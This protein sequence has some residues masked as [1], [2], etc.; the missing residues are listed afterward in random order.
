M[1]KLAVTIDQAR[2]AATSRLRSISDTARLDA[3]IILS[4]AVSVDRNMLN[5]IRDDTLNSDQQSDFE[6]LLSRRMAG[7]PI[8]YIT[9][10]KEFWS[11]DL[12]V[13]DAT[14]VPR[15]E[16]E[17]VVE[18]TLF[19]CNQLDTPYI[20]DLGTGCGAIALALA[21]ELAKSKITAT[22]ISEDALSIAKLNCKR[23]NLDNIRFVQGN[24]TDALEGMR[25][26]II[27][28]NPP[29]IREDDLCLKDIFMLH[30][31]KLA[32]TGGEDGFSAI[33]RIVDGSSKFLNPGG[34]L[35]IEHGFDQPD[36]VQNLM[37][38]NGFVEVSTNSDLAGLPRVT[39]GMLIAISKN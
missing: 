16:T 5:L 18:R 39:E 24:W 22:D 26:D 17:L 3:E 13:S 8:A 9:G 10:S 6:T 37:S 25:F 38:S 29:Y 34:W 31:P 4:E 27:A 2:Q 7:E 1:T 36:A 14:L 32:L 33:R 15:P 19:H 21:S 12:R 23:L 28:S 35:I 11:L 30:E 20:A